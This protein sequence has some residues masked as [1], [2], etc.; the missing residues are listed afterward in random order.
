MSRGELADVIPLDE[1]RKKKEAERHD[2]MYERVMEN[3]KKPEIVEIV[4]AVRNHEGRASEIVSNVDFNSKGDD[5]DIEY[6]RVNFSYKGVNHWASYEYNTATQ[7]A[8]FKLT[9]EPGSV[10]KYGK[11]S[12]KPGSSIYAPV[13]D[14]SGDGAGMKGDNFNFRDAEMELEFGGV[15]AALE[16]LLIKERMDLY[17]MSDEELHEELGV[18]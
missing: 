6:G 17:F 13:H 11:V 9:Q 1:R 14:S 2:G 18:D 4:E 10:R 7:K 5:G 8:T 12:G 15:T 3:K 16:V